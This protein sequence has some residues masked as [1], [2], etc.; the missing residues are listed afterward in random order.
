[1]P[2]DTPA[3]P[4]FPTPAGAVPE[5]PA[6]LVDLDRR[7]LPGLDGADLEP[8]DGPT[9]YDEIARE[10]DAQIAA[11]TVTLK[12]PA[13]PGW[14]LTFGLNIAEADMKRHRRSATNQKAMRRAVDD[15]DRADAIREVDMSLLLLATYNVGI[16]RHGVQLTDSRTGEPMTLRSAEW[17]QDLSG[18]ATATGAVFKLYGGVEAD[19]VTAGREL[20][21]AAGWTRRP[22]LADDDEEGLPA[23]GPTIRRSRG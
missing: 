20:I 17:I 6:A 3:T 12:V 21:D 19:V 16:V 9:P 7:E 15:L 2:N 13:R 11:R 18:V 14:E 10:L 4:D 22:E 5:G 1:V 23:P 8:S